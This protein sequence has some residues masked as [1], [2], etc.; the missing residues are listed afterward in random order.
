MSDPTLPPSLAAEIADLKRRLNNL[1]RSQRLPFS[2][3]R[4]GAFLFLDDN[5]QP[6]MT[7]GNVA[8]DGSVGGVLAAYGLMLRGDQGAIVLMTRAGDDGIVYP[9]LP[10]PIW[11]PGEPNK[12]T[13][14]ATFVSMWEARWDFP[15][16]DVYRCEGFVASAVGTT[17]EMRLV[18]GAT[19]T[20]VLAI[21]AAANNTYSFDWIH[22]APTGLY[23]P[24]STEGSLVVSIQARRT[25]G[26]GAVGVRRPHLSVLS[27]KLMRSLA[28]TSGHPTLG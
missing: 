6:R 23:D 26:A 4:G 12:D 11:D 10:V 19:A 27:S 20:S 13:T 2:S 5:G 9:E 1:E 8:L 24:S 17:G 18:I 28:D 14:S 22:P 15:P 7:L 3:T 25:G 16:S 21:P